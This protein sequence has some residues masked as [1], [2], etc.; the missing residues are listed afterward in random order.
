M[1][2]TPAPGAPTPSAW[3]VLINRSMLNHINTGVTARVG[4]GMLY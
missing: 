3:E 2:R 4:K 1:K